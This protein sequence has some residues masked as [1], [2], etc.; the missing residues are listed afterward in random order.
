MPKITGGQDGRPLD[1][2][3]AD[4]P[5]L[6]DQLPE[7]WPWFRGALQKVVQAALCK[8]REQELIPRVRVDEAHARPCSRVPSELKELLCLVA[9]VALRQRSILPDVQETDPPA[10]K[11]K[12]QKGGRVF[13]AFRVYRIPP[14][15]A[16][17][18]SREL[19][20][21]GSMKRTS[22]AMPA[23]A[24]SRSSWATT[25]LAPIAGSVAERL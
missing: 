12:L 10:I 1:L 20:E 4:A 22:A 2:R 3:E 21:P 24:Q 15:G 19:C 5:P 14:L 11:G 25:P 6:E 23:S 9:V 17:L 7:G 8:G 18:N 16:R 13:D